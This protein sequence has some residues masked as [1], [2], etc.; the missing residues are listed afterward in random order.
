MHEKLKETSK[1]ELTNE[2]SNHV[3]K[4][5]G[6]YIGDYQGDLF[7]KFNNETA[8]YWNKDIDVEIKV[9]SNRKIDIINEGDANISI[10]FVDNINKIYIKN[11]KNNHNISFHINDDESIEWS[12]NVKYNNSINFSMCFNY[13]YKN[14]LNNVIDELNL[15]KIQV[16]NKNCDIVKLQDINNEN[17]IKIVKLKKNID[18]LQLELND[19]INMNSFTNSLTDTYYYLD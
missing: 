12:F 14:I 19:K 1:I 15:M 10:E 4:T 13:D 2:Q 18:K 11:L 6:V 9:N 16:S 8:W 17:N 3:Y 7:L 5:K